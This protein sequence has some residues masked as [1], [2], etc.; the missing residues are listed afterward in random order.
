MLISEKGVSMVTVSADLSSRTCVSMKSITD[1]SDAYRYFT[2]VCWSMCSYL[3]N[4]AYF[5][6]S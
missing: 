6:H 1:F 5:S 2:S 3:A 4:S